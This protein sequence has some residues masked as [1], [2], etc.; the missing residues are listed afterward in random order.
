[1]ADGD[2][3][4][5]PDGCL[6]RAGHALT[7]NDGCIA[8]ARHRVTA[9]LEQAVTAHR[10]TVSDRVRDLTRLVVSELVTN[11]R[12][13]APGPI[14]M[15]LAIDADH[16]EVTVWDSDPTVPTPRGADPGRIGQHGLEIVQAVTES[17][18]IE[19]G[20]VG[21]RVTARLALAD[22]PAARA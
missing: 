14:L 8:D 16:V 4:P 12:K 19:R 11:A 3:C 21:K 2:G 13:Y 20:P 5:E 9:F 6:L 17:L 15:E 7:G 18:R 22:P 10:L 1:M